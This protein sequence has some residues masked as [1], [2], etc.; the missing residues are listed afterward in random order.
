[1]RQLLFSTITLL[2][3]SM[4]LTA[5]GGSGDGGGA[6]NNAPPAK[7]NPVDPNPVDPFPA[8]ETVTINELAMLDI[9]NTAA[10]TGLDTPLSDIKG[11]SVTLP[12]LGFFINNRTT[13]QRES[14]ATEWVE[15]DSLIINQQITPTRIASPTIKLT[16]NS[17]GAISG[18]TASYLTNN[19]YTATANAGTT[20]SNIKFDG[21]HTATY[22]DADGKI[23]TEQTINVEV[24]R[25]E[26]FFGF[27]SDYMAYISW[28]ANR[29]TDL[30][31]TN[32]STSATSYNIDG[33]MITGIETAENFTDT[34]KVAFTGNGRG[35]Y[36]VVGADNLLTRYHT[37]FTA[38]IA[39]DFDANKIA[40]DSN[41]PSCVTREGFG[42]CTDDAITNALANLNISGASTSLTN[43]RLDNV[44]VTV[45]NMIGRLDARFYGTEAQEFG[46]TF[47]LAQA[48]TE[49]INGRYYYGAFGT[50]RKDADIFM[51]TNQ[52]RINKIG[53]LPSTYS[54]T[55]N[56]KDYASLDAVISDNITLAGL[57]VTLND[58]TT[59][60]RFPT[61]KWDVGDDNLR[62]DRQISPTHIVSPAVTFTF[63][64][65]GN[66]ASVK[67]SYLG[68]EYTA[69]ASEVLSSTSF[70][71]GYTGDY[72][73]ENGVV[74]ADQSITVNVDRSEDF[75][76][77]NSDYMAYV[78]WGADRGADLT[79]ANKN[80]KTA[81]FAIDGMVIAGIQTDNVNILS[82]GLAEFT[83]AG[84]GV[85]GTYGSDNV[86]RSYNTS[87]TANI[88]V[89]FTANN[90][91]LNSTTPKCVTGLGDCSDSAITDALASLDITGA[92]IS[93]T[94]DK[95]D[96]VPIS[97]YGMDG[98]LD[99]RFYGAEAQEFGGT[100]LLSG[101]TR[102]YY[103]AFG[104]SRHGILP[105]IVDSETTFNA[106][107][108]LVL[109][110]HPTDIPTYKDGEN[111]VE[112][113]SLS[114]I[115][116]GANTANEAKTATLQATTV[117]LNDT[118]TY[119]RYKTDTAWTDTA[120]L[121]INRQITPTIINSSHV[122]LTFDVDG[123][124][125]SVA[126]RYQ[127]W[128]YV[129]TVAEDATLSATNFTGIY[130]RSYTYS[131]IDINVDVDRKD[132]FGF[133]SNNMAY[134]SW[135]AN[136]NFSSG[137]LTNTISNGDGA[138]LTGIETDEAN[139]SGIANIRFEGKGKGV[140]GTADGNHKTVFDI[141][142][143][144]DIDTR[145]ITFNASN[146]DCLSDDCSINEGYLNFSATLNYGM[147][148]NNASDADVTTNGGDL[149][150]RADARFYGDKA[151]EFGGTFLLA[152]VTNASY[153]Y[154]A[155]G[156]KYVGVQDY[157]FNK[158]INILTLDE[159]AWNTANP[160][161][162]FPNLE[163][164][165]DKGGTAYTSLEAL[166]TDT[167]LDN[168]SIK[169][170]TL[171]VLG[172]HRHYHWNYQR[173]DTSIEWNDSD[174]S[175][176]A[177]IVT[178]TNSVISLNY[179]VKNGSVYY[180][181]GENTEGMVL[182]RQT[183]N[184]DGEAVTNRYAANTGENER[185]YFNGNIVGIDSNVQNYMTL[186]RG[187]E[188]N[189]SSTNFVGFVP[190]NIV[191]FYWYIGEDK[192]VL[193]A[194]NLKAH[195]EDIFN[196]AIA[197]L[198]TGKDF[199]NGAFGI[200]P[201]PT[202]NVTFTGRGTAYYGYQL[203]KKSGST[204]SKRDRLHF[205][206]AANV[207]FNA[208]NI[209]LSIYDN[210]FAGTCRIKRKG[211]DFNA[212]NISFDKSGANVNNISKIVTT[213]NGLLTGMLDARFY[214]NAAQE[215]GGSFTMTGI[216][217]SAIYYYGIFASNQTFDGTN[218]RFSLN[219]KRFESQ[220]KLA[221]FQSG[222]PITIQLPYESFNDAVSANEASQF[223]ISGSAIQTH[224]I[225]DYERKTLTTDWASTD[226]ADV[227]KTQD[228]SLVRSDAPTL[229]LDFD[230]AGKISEAE[231]Y[232]GFNI[233]TAVLADGATSITAN[234]TLADGTNYSDADTNAITVDRNA[235]GFTSDYMVYVGWDFTKTTLSTDAENPV[236]ADDI[237]NI[238]GMMVAGIDTA[239]MPMMGMIN[240]FGT[241]KGNYGD[242]TTNHAVTFKTVA[243]VDFEK[244]KTALEISKT[245]CV[246]DACTLDDTMLDALNFTE[247]LTYDKGKNSDGASMNHGDL[248]G[249]IYTRFYGTG[250]DAAAEFG[251]TFMLKNSTHYYY[252]AFGTVETGSFTIAAASDIETITIASP[253]A[254]AIP[255]KPATANSYAWFRDA[256]VNSADKNEKL[257]TL[258][259]V[260]VYGGNNIDYSRTAGQDWRELDVIN[261][262][263][264]A[265]EV[266][267]A[268]SIT[269]N[270]SQKISDIVLH[271]D[272]KSYSVDA[273]TTPNSSKFTAT[274]TGDDGATGSLTA[275]R[276]G[277]IFG[278]YS[279]SLVYVHWNFSKPTLS[280]N[281]DT[282]SIYEKRGM[283]IV[284]VESKLDDIPLF[285]APVLG[286]NT[287]NLFKGRGRGYYNRASGEA[288]LISLFN[289]TANVDFAN[290]MVSISTDSNNLCN[291]Q[292]GSCKNNTA[293]DFKT[294]APL[295][296]ADI[297]GN[298][299]SNG[300][301]G[302]IA[303]K[304]D[305]NNFE[306]T[307][308][309][310]FYGLGA[311]EF[312]GTFAMIDDDN[313]HFYGMFASE[314][315]NAT[316]DYTIDE[317][318]TGVV[319][320][321]KASN[322][323]ISPNNVTYP[324]HHSFLD[325]YQDASPEGHTVTS[326]MNVSTLALTAYREDTIRYVRSQADTDGATW[327]NAETDNV[328]VVANIDNSSSHIQYYTTHPDTPEN[329][330][331][332][333]K[334][335]RI[336]AHK[337]S[338]AS[339]SGSNSHDDKVA[340]DY[341]YFKNDASL[342]YY[343]G[344]GSVSQNFDSMSTSNLTVMRP[345]E[346]GF[347]AKYM[348]YIRWAYDR[349]SIALGND[350]YDTGSDVDGYMLSGFETEHNTRKNAVGATDDLPETGIATFKGG[351]MGTYHHGIGQAYRTRFDA[352]A[353]VDF[354]GTND[355]AN[356]DLTL[357]N[358]TCE[359]GLG[360][361]ADMAITDILSSLNINNAMLTFTK[362]VNKIQD[363]D[364]IVGGMNGQI[365][366]K[367]YGQNR[368]APR[369]N[370]AEEF[371]GAF[372]FR[373]GEKSY[374][375]IFGA[376][377]TADTTACPQ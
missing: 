74:F 266:G 62:I 190:N 183:F 346:F 39:V 293:L 258:H 28:N 76:G 362:G 50:T 260:A 223:V 239:N 348:A 176:T 312:G 129:A 51:P 372:S 162:P 301:S 61:D 242:N 369:D 153:Y 328:T 178:N 253:E 302:A 279:D 345:T 27:D 232:F 188:P 191:V 214:G 373:K 146:T 321:V 40:L 135:R 1:M 286:E 127:D 144:V 316:F 119:S 140:Y 243:E 349:D 219:E 106:P 68:Q 329:K 33:M 173:V 65:D 4:A 167:G 210:C 240:F 353:S 169:T 85:Y 215:F 156:G 63:N 46:G 275:D 241:G 236:L 20:P 133:T 90:L 375:G 37:S 30:E 100:F 72:T 70:T 259:S 228:I 99:A 224:N 19:N 326:I 244:R 179:H 222:Y 174:I 265:K 81:T 207:D 59:Y 285:N 75:F 116:A 18:V 32:D 114:A 73:D 251:G 154:G 148:M 91:T 197:G 352:S 308:D 205:N 294:V 161:N 339:Q 199:G 130:N 86:I 314:N 157:T 160:L 142:A 350:T 80:T 262:I 15:T 87:F 340:D 230:D 184:A 172:T 238:D 42:A 211:L 57:S 234:G 306:G 124:I 131:I 189:Q 273:G 361:C 112:Y 14:T 351:G 198:E 226:D 304:D 320:R 290:K 327:E 193:G 250:N 95:L 88:D 23:F 101:A 151:Q 25:S 333:I 2:I 359:A 5:C 109:T 291:L 343:D 252:G 175:N 123:N 330:G 217:D 102:Y 84:R 376:C 296:Y 255:I 82:D 309:A 365:D 322:P 248:R 200:F 60:T 128:D 246:T 56:S 192:S 134:V 11:V 263:F 289:V 334:S 12:L 277:A 115:S 9:T 159:F 6:S 29:A 284:G 121:N 245:A 347:T 54:H 141:T 41:S 104:T 105:F 158:T 53:E 113:N 325:A 3:F 164:P 208:G 336:F 203:A 110:L 35:I 335:V 323:L 67:S 185:T 254:V 24:D 13:Y 287:S 69:T 225:T 270:G 237:Y 137:G 136:N 96:N 220:H 204:F 297:N 93:L 77:F 364:V 356:I 341:H 213:S 34:G 48:S 8:D 66:I 216:D 295:S 209:N 267:A 171:P 145:N 143:D 366:A 163:I 79:T 187:D 186:Y 149:T 58:I 125:S 269:V 212:N 311:D 324:I 229:V 152:N 126:S 170:F 292:F 303:S 202:D 16:F 31:E 282:D 313:N 165:T 139:I 360:D 155:F 218:D 298:I 315:K 108:T 257:F 317:Y 319:A 310:K 358:T 206:V 132:I 103:G 280:D 83:G 332:E 221:D 94:N 92:A 47:A 52:T 344:N 21:S 357:N 10:A 180:Q 281:I 120:N 261:E 44:L 43:G 98:R 26:N 231:I 195:T 274:I 363:T 288:M 78:S 194:D 111:D 305:S 147:G 354:E 49:T 36:G 201:T 368:G 118:R 342:N 370:A 107:E 38:N 377:D 338:Y 7:T 122:T 166:R 233:Y 249:A 177:N 45:D 182:Y 181:G 168:D 256:I 89:D 278:F 22:T 374:I 367:F 268:A 247:S 337:L 371:G 272:G 227:S 271:L 150:G 299:I 235:F 300:V 196:M 283:M 117:G 307:V 64:T 138:T 331:G 355:V 276:R 71:G 318:D 264:V 97:V 17:D 55:I